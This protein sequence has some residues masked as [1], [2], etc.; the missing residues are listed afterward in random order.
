MRTMWINEIIEGRIFLL[1]ILIF[2]RCRV[3]TIRSRTCVLDPT[4]IL[5]TENLTPT[6]TIPPLSLFSKVTSLYI[7]VVCLKYIT[8]D[9]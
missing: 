6:A 7:D 9:L 1:P 3:L 5:Q 8:R 4:F 2:Y